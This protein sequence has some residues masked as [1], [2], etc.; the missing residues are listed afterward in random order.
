MTGAERGS[1]A[2]E[3]AVVAPALV[4]LL[5]LV[6]LAGRVSHADAQV[7]RAAS[8]AARTASL[9]QSPDAAR[10]AAIDAADANLAD[11]GF[12][13]GE[14]DTDVDTAQFEPGGSVTVRVSCTASM[15]DVTL[16]GVP[17]FRTFVSSSTEV[18]DRYRGGDR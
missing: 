4:A 2:V 16:L 17:G 14:L 11:S 7:Q 10:Q 18:I 6:V 9:Y 3:V 1:V 12:V 8:V 5:L 13:C 15:Q